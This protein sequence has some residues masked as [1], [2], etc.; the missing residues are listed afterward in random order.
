MCGL[1]VDAAHKGNQQA[2][3]DIKRIMGI[4]TNV[5]T[6]TAAANLTSDAKEPSQADGFKTT[7]EELCSY[8]LHT[9]Y[10]GTSNSS[11]ATRSRAERLSHAL[12]GYHNAINIDAVVSAVLSV[13]SALTTV[14]GGGTPRVPRFESQGGTPTEDLALQNIQARIRMVMAYMCA[15]LFPWLRGRKGFLLVLGSANVRTCKLC[16]IHRLSLFLCATVAQHCVTA[17]EN[18]MPLLP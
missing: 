15:Q 3:R 4:P 11:N 16:I 17:S 13:F 5:V 2:I 12:G 14:V 10:M 1:A 18:Q 7:P 9:V 6:A 8:I